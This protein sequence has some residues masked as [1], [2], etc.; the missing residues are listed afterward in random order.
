MQKKFVNTL[1]YKLV[2]SQDYPEYV[3]AEINKNVTPSRLRE[4]PSQW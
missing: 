4:K 3:T 1:G 2:S